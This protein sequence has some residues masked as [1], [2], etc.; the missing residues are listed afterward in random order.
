MTLPYTHTHTHTLGGA[1][2]AGSCSV[3]VLKTS[4]VSVDTTLRITAIGYAQNYG[5]FLKTS[6]NA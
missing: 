4:V 3:F 2:T 6:R 1:G 5:G